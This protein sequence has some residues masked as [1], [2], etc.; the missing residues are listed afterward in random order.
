MREQNISELMSDERFA[1]FNQLFILFPMLKISRSPGL[2]CRSP[3]A[4]SKALRGSH[5][6]E[7]VHRTI[8]SFHRRLMQ[9]M[10][11]IKR[12]HGRGEL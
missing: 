5:Y 12:P 4:Q 10:Q 9:F 7:K 3:S 8:G 1:V 2:K 6:M 11:A